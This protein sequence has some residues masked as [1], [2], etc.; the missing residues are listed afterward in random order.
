MDIMDDPQVK[1]FT[2]IGKH[3][4]T[5]NDLL[6]VSKKEHAEA[7]HVGQVAQF[8]IDTR[9]NVIAALKFAFS[10]IPQQ[11]D[12]TVLVTQEQMQQLRD[13]IQA[14]QA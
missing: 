10:M 3:M 12:G 4:I 8:L 6:D 1:I 5:V 13:Q 2:L 9:D 14:I 11:P 7:V